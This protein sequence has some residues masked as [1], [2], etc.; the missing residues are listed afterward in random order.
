MSSSNI[1]PAQVMSRA[2]ATENTQG[3][4]QNLAQLGQAIGNEYPNSGSAPRL[5]WQEIFKNPLHLLNPAVSVA[6]PIAWATAQLI[7][8]PA[9]RA[10]LTN[11]V[12]T[13]EV[14]RLLMRGGGLLGYAGAS[15]AEP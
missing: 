6:A 15:A 14:E 5:L 12:M 13:P 11:G 10:Y 2:L 7:H 1:P 8:S 4:M 9:G 3:G